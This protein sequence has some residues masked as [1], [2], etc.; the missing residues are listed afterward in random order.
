MSYGSSLSD[1]NRLV[2]AYAGRI[3]K[4]VKPAEVRQE[5]LVRSSRCKS[6]PSKE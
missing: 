5:K 2:G 3:L 1:A 6:G 4:G